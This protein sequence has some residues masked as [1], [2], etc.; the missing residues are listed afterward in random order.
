M[1]EPKQPTP[2]TP[3]TNIKPALFAIRGRRS[4]SLFV[5]FFSLY[6]MDAVFAPAG[7]PPR[8][9]D[10]IQG[11]AFL[12][13]LKSGQSNGAKINERRDEPQEVT[14]EDKKIKGKSEGISSSVII[15]MASFEAVLMW[16]DKKGIRKRQPSKIT[17]SMKDKNFLIRITSFIFICGTDCNKKTDFA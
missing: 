15:F 8:K 7:K 9:P 13:I 2:R 5:I 1:K 3:T 16:E 4:A 10:I 17:N 12:L 11:T 6:R 14:R